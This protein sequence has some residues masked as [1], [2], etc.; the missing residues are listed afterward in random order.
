LE[1]IVYGDAAAGCDEW[2]GCR[3]LRRFAAMGAASGLGRLLCVWRLRHCR[4]AIV[5]PRHSE[6]PR[7]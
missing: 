5:M 4:C 3:S 6:S 7:A 2:C 1:T